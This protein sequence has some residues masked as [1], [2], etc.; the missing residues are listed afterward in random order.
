MQDFLYYLSAL[1]RSAVI[2]TTLFLALTVG[3]GVPTAI[4]G[5]LRNVL[6]SSYPYAH[7][8]GMYHLLVTD[9]EGNFVWPLYTEEQLRE[10]LLSAFTRTS[11]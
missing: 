7:S 11:V 1:K 2:T 3:I 5:I 4:F 9:P 10:G 6:I 8:D